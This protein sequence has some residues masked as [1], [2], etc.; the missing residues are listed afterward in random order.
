MTILIKLGVTYAVIKLDVSV[1]VSK[2]YNQ[3]WENQGQL[4]PQEL[5]EGNRFR[6]DMVQESWKQ[7]NA[8]LVEDAGT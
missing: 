5:E 6:L 2:E 8:A 3:C 7:K 4:G 1:S